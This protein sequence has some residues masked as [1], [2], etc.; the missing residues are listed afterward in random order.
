MFVCVRFGLDG[1]GL[2]TSLPLVGKNVYKLTC[3]RVEL[4]S[5][6]TPQVKSVRVLPSVKLRF[7]HVNCLPFSEST[8][9]CQF[10]CITSGEARSANLLPCF[11]RL[12]A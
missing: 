2:V 10:C 7:V 1:S 12:C 4:D 3:F 5:T 8:T 6:I 11:C 9:R